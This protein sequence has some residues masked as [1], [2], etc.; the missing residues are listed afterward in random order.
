MVSNNIT[1]ADIILDFSAR[2]VKVDETLV[3]P[4]HRKS[5][6]YN[7]PNADASHFEAAASDAPSNIPD[8]TLKPFSIWEHISRG[9][10]ADVYR[11]AL[12]VDTEKDSASQRAFVVKV[13]M[14]ME[15]VDNLKYETIMYQYAPDLQGSV[16]PR[17]Y[18]YYENEQG[19][20]LILLEDCGRPYDG[21]LQ[22]LPDHTKLAIMQA[23]KKVHDAGLEHGDLEPWNLLDYNGSPRIVDWHLGLI[24]DCPSR[25]LAMTEEFCNREAIQE[26]ICEEIVSV[27]EEM[28]FRSHSEI[29]YSP[30][31]P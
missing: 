7:Q 13:A 28:M 2:S 20:A 1:P 11:G 26:L 22:D 3:G 10:V 16:L 17:C 25:R 24:H 9:S 8:P 19:A 23:L 5:V 14:G 29:L 31:N 18:G 6:S 21:P 27:G 12:N 4:F 15:G 30:S